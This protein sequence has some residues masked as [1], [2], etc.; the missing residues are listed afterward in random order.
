MIKV[1]T[2]GGKEGVKR[3]VIWFRGETPVSVQMTSAHFPDP[4]TEDVELDE[5]FAYVEVTPRQ[6]Q[7]IFAL[8][9]DKLKESK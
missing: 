8:L 1:N 2:I 5:Q 6:A 4:D 7:E 9:G 3:Y